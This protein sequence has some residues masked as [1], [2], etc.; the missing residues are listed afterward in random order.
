MKRIHLNG[1]E[2]GLQK[3]G[4]NDDVELIIRLRNSTMADQVKKQIL[5]DQEFREKHLNQM[6]NREV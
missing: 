1:E 4:Y 6:E 5:S 2:F 3:F